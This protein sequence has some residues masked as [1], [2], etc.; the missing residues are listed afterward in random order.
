MIPGCSSVM[1]QTCA[2]TI[3]SRGGGSNVYM[4]LYNTTTTALL[5]CNRKF[6]SDRLFF[7]LSF[8]LL[9]G[10]MNL[11]FT[12]LFLSCTFEDMGIFR[13]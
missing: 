6:C 12:F 5:L 3:S 4:A 2:V 11:N 1:F 10:G 8:L 7:L 9:E 13:D